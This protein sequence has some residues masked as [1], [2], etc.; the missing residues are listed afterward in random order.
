MVIHECQT[1]VFLFVWRRI[2]WNF[3]VGWAQ[4]QTI[5]L[6]LWLLI[7]G[8]DVLGSWLT[9]W[10]GKV[11]G[12]GEKGRTSLEQR[13]RHI[14]GL[15]ETETES[16]KWKVLAQLLELGSLLALLGRSLLIFRHY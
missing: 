6:P 14:A 8:T 3:H 11:A 5:Q 13:A 7:C 1:L 15:P 10:P 4:F 12:G 2:F 9:G 16:S